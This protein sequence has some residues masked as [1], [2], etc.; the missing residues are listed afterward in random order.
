MII[1]KTSKY[2]A[3]FYSM[4]KKDEDDD[5]TADPFG[6]LRQN[7]QKKVCERQ[8]P[9]V[10]IHD[11]AKV[12]EFLANGFEDIEALGPVDILRRGG[13]EVKTVSI[14]GSL[15]VESAHGVRV[16]ADILFGDADFSDADM[17]LIP[18]GMPG[19]KNID[20]HE[21][22]RSAV[23]RHAEAGKLL[24][25]ICAGPMILGHLGLLRGRRAT[26]YP[27]FEGELAGAEYTAEPFTV[28]GNVITGKGP[29]ATFAYAYRILEMFKGANVVEELKH[30]MMYQ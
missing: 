28:D 12:Y 14:S 9:T 27:G 3:R 25:A 6:V 8:K 30:G 29:G 10:N 7:V 13:V 17:L 1:A 22:V 15:E 5:K 23:T 2:M 16:K 26:C 18:G 20:E 21:G 19:A 24:G 4:K 11:M